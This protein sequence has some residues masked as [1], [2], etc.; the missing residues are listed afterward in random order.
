MEI[1]NNYYLLSTKISIICINHNTT[2][3]QYEKKKKK[4][5]LQSLG[6]YKQLILK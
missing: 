4:I 6:N 3:T 5:L 1:P 2:K